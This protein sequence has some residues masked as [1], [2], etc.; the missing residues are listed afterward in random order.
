MGGGQTLLSAVAGASTVSSLEAGYTGT[1]IRALDA[2][3]KVEWV[4]ENAS[5]SPR[6]RTYQDGTAGARSNV[7][8]RNP[9]APMIKYKDASGAERPVRFDGME[10]E[11]LIDRKTSVVTTAKAQEQALRQAEAL[12]QN[13]LR[14][15]WEVPNQTAATRATDMFRRLQINNIDVK[16]AP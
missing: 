13:G 15:R 3:G 5:M 12:R 16:V 9:Q 7:A 1:G 2:A 11:V 6:A 10:G 4:D 8:T 14:G